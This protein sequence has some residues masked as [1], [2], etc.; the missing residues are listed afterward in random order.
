[1]SGPSVVRLSLV[2]L[3]LA[4]CASSPD[5]SPEVERLLREG[6][7][8]ESLAVLKEA[9]GRSGSGSRERIDYARQRELVTGQLVAQADNARIAGELAFAQR[10]YERA[11]AIDPDMAR[12]TLGLELTRRETRYAPLLAAAEQ[13]LRAGEL[14]AAEQR[15]RAVLAEDR[16][17]R[18]AAAVTRAIAEERVRRGSAPPVLDPESMK[19]T[20]TLEF[21]E[22]P[23]RSVF[24]VLTRSAGINFVFDRDVRADLRTTI[25]IRDGTIS[26]VIDMLL[27]SNQLAKKVVDEKTVL[28]YPNTAQKQREHQELI[29]KSFYLTNADPRVTINLIRTIL[30]TR[31]VFIDEKLG[32]LVMR[33]TPE[34]I[35]LAEKLIATQDLAEPEVLLQVEVLEVGRNKLQELGVRWPDQLAYS[36]AGSI[37]TAGV[38]TLPEWLNRGA[39]LVRMSISN[40]FF[41]INLR[42]QDGETNLLSNPR[43][44]VKNREKAKVHVGDRVPVITS[45]ATTGGFVSQSVNYIDVG[46]K[47]DVEPTVLLDN[48]VSIR[49]GLEVSNIVREVTS[50]STAGSTLTYQIGTRNAATVLRLR[51]GETQILA[52][53]ISDEDRRTAN[54][55]PGIGE[56]PVFGRLFSNQ[57][58]SASKNE[59][60]LLITPRIVRGL[61]RPDATIIEFN[62]GTETSIGS[63]SA[64]AGAGSSPGTAPGV[65][66][67]PGAAGGLPRG[68]AKPPAP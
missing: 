47:L 11:L 57:S 43:I 9:A 36:L 32:L 59:I 13:H 25:F 51:D 23:V 34:A 1:M 26:R 3:L 4:A 29:V 28:V 41:I 61:E 52:G 56:L 44:R 2:T 22:V 7:F 63:G 5:R 15:L 6:R 50:T 58:T 39:E 14:E 12:A 49:V 67:A 60:V 40:P 64:G 21:R 53:L 19:K 35:R 16:G 48:E 62:S 66:A 42:Q 38:L 10:L 17:H 65:P 8:E 33:D 30:K 27:A 24:E 68:P 37:G 18:G 20:V 46:L 45:T 54:R 55:V 31:D